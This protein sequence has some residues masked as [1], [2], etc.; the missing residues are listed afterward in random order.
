MLDR[1]KP[2]EPD[3]RSV[4]A[5]LEERH[6]DLCHRI[7]DFVA[8]EIATLPP[9]GDDTA[10]RAQARQIL[11]LLGDG[12]WLRAIN[13]LDLRSCCLIRES[14]AAAS[15]LADEVFA[16]QALGSLPIALAGTPELRERWLPGALSGTKMAAFAMTEPEAGSDVAAIATRA[17]KKGSDYLIDGEKTL[18]SNA[19][20]A[21]FYTLFVKTDATAGHRG[22]SCFVVE[23]SAP[24]LEFVGP[25]ALSA[26]HPLGELVFRGCRVPASQRIG[27]EGSGFKLGMATL[28][29]LRATVA[30]SACGMARRA[31]DE[32]MS[33]AL[34][35][36]QFGSALADFQAIQ[37][38]LAR[39]A[40]ELAASR[41][42]VYRA[43]AAKDRGA[44]RVTLES[45]MAKAFATEAAQ[46]IIDDAV[47]IVGGRAVLASH[48]LDRLY[49][50]IRPLRIY[51]GTTDIQH[52]VIAR[53]L[54]KAAAGES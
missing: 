51:E 6:V 9:P 28:D 26:P 49:R 53:T 19:G 13:P 52:L 41:L 36:R 31:L 2:Y 8:R 3:A 33:H 45:S 1:E 4:R 5:F 54:L 15:S 42:L 22:I 17:E 46:R 43:A 39:M 11:G 24:G 48:P 44:E 38:K 40:T 7:G 21:D 14:L 27:D 18:I 50:A 34:S 23:A 47:Q 10:A 37:L 20:I 16:L 25:L 12:G 32:A 35:R 30:A 29:A